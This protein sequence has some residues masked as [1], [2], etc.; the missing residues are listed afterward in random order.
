MDGAAIER[1]EQSGIECQAEGDR[2]EGGTRDCGEGT[3]IGPS[4]GFGGE[5]DPAEIFGENQ[6]VLRICRRTVEFCHVN[7]CYAARLTMETGRSVA[8]LV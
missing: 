6:P 7:L 5:A 8:G 1:L 2:L 3:A 4:T